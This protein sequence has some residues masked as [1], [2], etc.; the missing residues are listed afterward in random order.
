M[1]RLEGRDLLSGK[2]R[3]ATD[4][5]LDGMLHAAFERSPHAHAKILSIDAA[6][7]LKAPGVHTV[8][9]RDDIRE[10]LVTDRL[11]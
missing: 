5:R 11:A 3:F 7:A 4:I 10:L 9:T 1:P 8:L 6:D 2:G